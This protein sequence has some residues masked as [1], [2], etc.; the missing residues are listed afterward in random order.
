MNP[1]EPVTLP[2]YELEALRMRCAQLEEENNALE[3]T[4]GLSTEQLV[5]L[6]CM[7]Y[8]LC[9]PGGPSIRKTIEANA[10]KEL[11]ECYPITVQHVAVLGNFCCFTAMNPGQLQDFLWRQLFLWQI[12]LHGPDILK[13]R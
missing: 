6:F 10:I 7:G 1:Y 4:S 9:P 5:R 8:N 3:S 12:G 2:R 11:L 13:R